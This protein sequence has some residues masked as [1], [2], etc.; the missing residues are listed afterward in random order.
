MWLDVMTTHTLERLLEETSSSYSFSHNTMLL[1]NER[2]QWVSRHFGR[3]CG[4]AQSTQL[5]RHNVWRHRPQ[6]VAHI[7]PTWRYG[8]STVPTAG[9]MINSGLRHIS[10]TFY[11]FGDSS[12][13]REDIFSSGVMS[14][15]YTRARW[16][17]LPNL[18]LN[19][20]ALDEFGF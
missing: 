8:D 6:H 4:S 5:S 1:Q 13:R 2:W 3:Y 14:V 18:V 11:Q 12:S 7:L 10:D 9:A 15:T 19:Q 16:V 20:V 17:C